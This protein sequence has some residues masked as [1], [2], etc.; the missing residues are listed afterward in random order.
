MVQPAEQHLAV[1]GGVQRD[2]LADPVVRLE[3]RRAGDLVEVERRALR[4]HGDVDGLAGVGGELAADRPGL[5]D[6]VEP[7][8]G[9]AGQPEHADAEAVLARGRSVCSTRRCASRVATRRN[10]VLLWTPSSAAISVTPASPTRARTSRMRQRPVDRLDAGAASRV[11]AA[12]A[13]L[14][15]GD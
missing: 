2:V 12:S 3:R 5:L 11:V 9:R 15:A 14:M 13:L 1:A 7:R 10:A 6:H 8:A 4:E